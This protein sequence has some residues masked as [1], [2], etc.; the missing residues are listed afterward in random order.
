[1]SLQAG[2]LIIT[3][4]KPKTL[5]ALELKAKACGQTPEEYVREFLE[6]QSASLSGVQEQ[7]HQKMTVDEWRHAMEDLA[8]RV[9]ASIPD[10]PSLLDT[11]TEM[12]R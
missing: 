11:L 1:M 4:L 6:R 8:Q 5:E 12:R 10:G 9:S 3:G 2:T 7:E